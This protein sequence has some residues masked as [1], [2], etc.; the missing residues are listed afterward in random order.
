MRTKPWLLRSGTGG[1][2]DR[3]PVGPADAVLLRWSACGTCRR[4]VDAPGEAIG[5]KRSLME[6]PAVLSF[7]VLLWLA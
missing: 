4:W 2:G 3:P 5:G 7:A 6:I 1:T